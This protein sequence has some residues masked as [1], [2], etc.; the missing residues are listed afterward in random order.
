MTY[1]SVCNWSNFASLI[2]NYVINRIV[3]HFCV[4]SVVPLKQVLRANVTVKRVIMTA[5]NV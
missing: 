1:V 5:S 3:H 2:C 4:R